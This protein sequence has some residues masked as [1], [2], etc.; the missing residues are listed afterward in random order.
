M[1][2]VLT[3]TAE[4]LLEPGTDRPGGHGDRRPLLH[5]SLRVSLVRAQACSQALQTS[6]GHLKHLGYPC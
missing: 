5:S 2:H 4:H 1:A 6:L 3:Y